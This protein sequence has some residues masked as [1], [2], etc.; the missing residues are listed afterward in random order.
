MLFVNRVFEIRK[1]LPILNKFRLKYYW[2]LNSISQTIVSFQFNFN[3]KLIMR[4]CT[5]QRYKCSTNLSGILKSLFIIF[6]VYQQNNCI[7]RNDCIFAVLQIN[8]YPPVIELMRR[9]PCIKRAND[10]RLRDFV[11][12][13]ADV[14]SKLRI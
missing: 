5:Y 8:S 2:Y 13:H 14:P 10:L 6:I 3:A 9:E 11:R 7:F 1:L 4:Y 12:T